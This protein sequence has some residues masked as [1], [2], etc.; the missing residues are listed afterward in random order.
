VYTKTTGAGLS[1]STGVGAT[2]R[3][4]NFRYYAERTPELP[5]TLR[6]VINEIK[7]SPI[8]T[9]MLDYLVSLIVGDFR[10]AED[11][12]VRGAAMAIDFADGNTP[13]RVKR[14]RQA[15]LKLRKEPG[16]INEIYKYKDIAYEKILPGYGIAGKDV[17]GASYFVIGDEKQMIAYENY[18]KT[19]SNGPNA[20]LF[21]FYP[22]DFWLVHVI[23]IP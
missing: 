2:P 6:F 3:T 8:D 11:Y 14:F 19:T 12:E 13:N 18:L 4:G 5:Q 23:P 1:Y 20:K 10:S 22:R 9:S 16:V 7:K 17:A 15:I 21:R